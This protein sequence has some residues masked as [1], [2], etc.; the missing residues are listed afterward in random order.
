M[1]RFL[2]S[3]KLDNRSSYN[4]FLIRKDV[5]FFAFILL[6]TAFNPNVFGANKTSSVDLTNNTDQLLKSLIE[7]RSLVDAKSEELALLRQE[8][9]QKRKYTLSRISELS[10]AVEH[11]ELSIKKIDSKLEK[12]RTFLEE[13][14]RF[15]DLSVELEKAIIVL[16]NY[17]LLSL[18]FKRDERLN[19]LN[20]IQQELETKAVSAPRLANKLWAFVED[21][22]MLSKG[23]GIYRQVVTIDSEEKLVDVAR[24]GMMMLYY[25]DGAGNVGMAIK[26]E[27]NDADWQFTYLNNK[28]DQNQIHILFDAFQKQVRFGKFTLPNTLPNTVV[29]RGS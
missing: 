10:S 2:A 20:E 19:A 11:K 23:N 16:S 26:P 24:I 8:S 14:K 28:K 27:N 6:V 29:K 21:E 12:N 18:P 22:I 15:D 9:K 25:R 13:N 4:F 1:A 17:V 3:N 5:L 7:L